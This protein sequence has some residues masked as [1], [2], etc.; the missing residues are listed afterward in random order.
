MMQPKTS[1]I[2]ITIGDELLIGQVIDTNS[3]W[4]ARALNEIGLSVTKRIAVGDNQAS[5]R[6]VFDQS[7]IEADVVLVTGGLG[8]TADDITKPL[9]CNYFESTLVSHEP[10]L[11]HIR[12]LFD[13][14]HKRPLTER[15]IQQAQVPACCTPLFNAMGTAPG[16]W[17]EKNGKIL[18]SLPGVPIEMQFLMTEEVIPRLQKRFQNHSIEHRTLI[19]H[20]IGE[21]ALADL[22]E[23]FETQLPASIKLAYLPNHGFVRLR[24]TQHH[25]AQPDTLSIEDVF[26]TLKKIVADH[27]IWDRD[28]TMDQIIFGL[29]QAQHK[30]MATAESCSGGYIAHLLTRNPGISSV[31]KGSVIAYAYD[32]KTR[33]L[34]VP[35]QILQTHGAVSEET[36]HHMLLGVLDETGA[37]VG[38]AVSGIMG[39]DG[40]TPEKP[41]GTVCIAVGDRHH[42]ILKTYRFR[43]NREKNIHLTALYAL[44]LLR[45]FL[46]T[47]VS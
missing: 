14:V 32:V 20:G 26:D 3:A 39:P 41:V 46:A 18:I 29:L 45:S 4:M 27:L 40:G 28:E 7:L 6:E 23:P 13:H 21:S 31:Y 35:E 1:A 43:F 33:S 42:P 25:S 24:L 15:N 17:F 8:P 19:T 16:M 47:A 9:L 10:T 22:L 37:D 34:G 44:N 30:T 5:I 12:H 38:I 36:V 11:D 2:I